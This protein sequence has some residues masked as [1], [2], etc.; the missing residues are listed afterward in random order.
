M[1]DM[2]PRH[3]GGNKTCVLEDVLVG[4]RMFVVEHSGKPFLHF[5]CHHHPRRRH[6][7]NAFR[8]FLGG[9]QGGPLEFRLHEQSTFVL[10]KVIQL[11][12][13]H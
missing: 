8:P 1:Q 11:V 12:K 13:R 3:D 5:R 2:G 6:P 7:L 4:W 9:G 10:T